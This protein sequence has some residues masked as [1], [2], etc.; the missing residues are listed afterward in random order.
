MPRPS[1]QREIARLV[2]N[3]AVASAALRGSDDVFTGT[4]ERPSARAYSSLFSG[5]S[6]GVRRHQ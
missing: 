4:P 3:S 5:R 6:G 1:G 2:D